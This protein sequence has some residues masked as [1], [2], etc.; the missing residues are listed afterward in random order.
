LAGQDPGNS[1]A[2][3]EATLREISI[4]REVA[5]H[6]YISEFWFLVAF[7][8]SFLSIKIYVIDCHC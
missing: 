5:G 4:L 7:V 6:P 8:I 3:R 2:L 1:D